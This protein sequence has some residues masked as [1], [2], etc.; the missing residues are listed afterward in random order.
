L[1]RASITAAP[2][3]AYLMS[4]SA[5]SAWQNSIPAVEALRCSVTFRTVR[6]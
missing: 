6:G 4:G 1:G 2:G 5:R 3:S